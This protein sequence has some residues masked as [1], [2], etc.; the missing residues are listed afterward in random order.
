MPRPR[1]MERRTT[2]S[3]AFNE[4]NLSKSLSLSITL[5]LSIATDSQ[6]TPFLSCHRQ[7]GAPENVGK[8][9]CAIHPVVRTNPVSGW[10]SIYA[11]G[12]HVEHINNVTPAESTRLLDWLHDIVVQNHDIHVRHRW[13]N[14]N[15][16]ALWDNR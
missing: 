13:V 4:E 3:K 14:N 1:L 5:S 6:L 10:N 7:R 2:P 16:M 9:I 11:L 12:H 15:D 8:H